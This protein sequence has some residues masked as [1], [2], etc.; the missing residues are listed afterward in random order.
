MENINYC[1]CKIMA[2]LK[3]CQNISINFISVPIATFSLWEKK[4]K[5]E[6]ITVQYWQNKTT[7]KWLSTYTE[8]LRWES[9]LTET[10]LVSHSRICRFWKNGRKTSHAGQNNKQVEKVLWSF[11][12]DWR[13]RQ[14]VCVLKLSYFAKKNWHNVTLDVWSW[15]RYSPK[16]LQLSLKQKNALKNVD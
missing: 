13:V 14:T 12:T 7:K 1:Q 6:T 5:T 11:E 15:F 16:D 10:L 4:L 2:K 9:L 8:Q 3:I